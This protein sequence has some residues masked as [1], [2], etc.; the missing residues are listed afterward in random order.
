MRFISYLNALISWRFICE[1]RE[2]LQDK[3]LFQSKLLNKRAL[4]WR[5]FL[6]TRR[7]ASDNFLSSFF[8]EVLVVVIIK[9]IVEIR[10]K[11]IVNC[12]VKV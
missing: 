5:L 12:I 6:I 8:L 10:A 11:V 9:V 4:D 7:L 1:V 2:N 3:W